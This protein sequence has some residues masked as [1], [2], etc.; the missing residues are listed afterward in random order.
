MLLASGH[1]CD[2][3]HGGLYVASVPFY[4]VWHQSYGA[5]FQGQY[6]QGK[7]ETMIQ[8]TNKQCWAHMALDWPSKASLGGTA[9]SRGSKAT[10]HGFLLLSKSLNIEFGAEAL[11]S[12]TQRVCKKLPQNFWKAQSLGQLGQRSTVARHVLGWG[13]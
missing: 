1:V 3:G 13:W 9:P 2:P 10:F 4:D 11:Y 6:T 12:L 8:E 5:T 7:L